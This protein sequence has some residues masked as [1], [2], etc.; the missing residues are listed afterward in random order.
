MSN[1]RSEPTDWHPLALE[2]ESPFSPFSS[3]AAPRPGSQPS[4][5]IAVDLGTTQLRMALWDLRARRRLAALAAA[6]PQVVFGT[7]IL[8][9]LAEAHESPQKARELAER[10]QAALGEGLAL[11]SQQCDADLRRIRK[12]AVVGNTAMLSLF[13]GESGEMLLQPEHWKR[14]I[15]CRLVGSGELAR[16]WRVAYNAQIALIQPLGGFVGSDLLAN[17]LAVNLLQAPAGSLLVDFGTNTELAL[18]DG[19]VLW[20]TSTPGGCA[21]AGPGILPARAGAVFRI[22]AEPSAALRLQ[23][24]GGGQPR[25]V[26]GSGLV[27]LIALLLERRQVDRVGRFTGRV[28]QEGLPISPE[29]PGL[30]LRKR[31]IDGFQR[32]KG[33]MAAAMHFILQRAGLKLADIPQLFVSGAF[34]Q[35]LHIGHAQAIGLLPAIPA[36]R[37]RLAGDA[38]LAGCEHVLLNPNPFPALATIR[39]RSILI[40]LGDSLEFEDLFIENLYLQPMTGVAN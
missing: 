2:D 8:S 38:A 20:V 14:E 10:V 4:F 6:N 24:I 29:L 13:S 34:G 40:N 5:G 3:P 7:N 15:A 11:I 19:K 23:V 1:S 9:R 12:L 27:D 22:A 30:I 28:S 31:D 32:G 17:V 33:A 18:W 25:G 37:I 16:R 21:F 35:C 26:C 36:Q 39:N